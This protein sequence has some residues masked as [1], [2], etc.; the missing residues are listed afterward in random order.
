MVMKPSTA[1]GMESI[2]NRLGDALTGMSS[3]VKGHYI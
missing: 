3:V 1:T 2:G